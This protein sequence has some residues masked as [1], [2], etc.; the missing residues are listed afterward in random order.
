MLEYLRKASSKP[1]AKILMGLLI[2][3]FVGWGVANWV[4]G[5]AASDDTIVRVGKSPIKI[6]EFENI[7]SRQIAQLSKTEQKQLYTVPGAMSQFYGHI[8]SG[9]TSRKMLANR[10]DYLGIHVSNAKIAA[11]IRSTP[12]FQL[13]GKFSPEKFDYVLRSAGLNEDT[14]ANYLRADIIRDMSV[15]GI[16]VKLPAPKFASDA[17]YKSKYAM[18]KIEFKSVP[19]ADFKAQKNPTDSELAN[20]YSQNPKIIPETR[21]VNYVLMPAKMETPDSYDHGYSAA[22]KMEDAIIGGESMKVAA[23][24]AGGKFISYPAF[25]ATNVPKDAILDDTMIARIFTMDSRC[26]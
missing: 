18:R 14:Y 13:N 1:V 15:A 25:G 7:K 17:L 21:S 24:N 6:A 22:Q 9:L 8:L 11:I 12:D 26:V 23:K 16:S 19:Y 5:Q 4:F 2:F 20:A 10:A 3:S